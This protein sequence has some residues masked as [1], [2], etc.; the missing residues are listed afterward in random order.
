MNFLGIQTRLTV[1][2]FYR[3]RVDGIFGQLS[4][5]A[6]LEAVA[7]RA[8]GDR[9]M[10]LGRAM[11]EQLPGHAIDTELRLA[12]FLAQAAHETAGFTRFLELGSGDGPDADPYDDYLQRYDGRADLGNREPGDGERYRGRGIFQLT[13]RAN[14]RRYGAKLGLPLEQ[15][16]ELAALPINAVRIAASYWT[17]RQINLAADRDDLKA[18]TKAING[19]LNG[20]ASRAAFLDQA[21]KYLGLSRTGA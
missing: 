14:Y 7:G 1:G 13:G 11:A 5:Q 16:P 8:L 17:E 21:R 18:V 3:A 15:R 10:A 19:G 20:L 6:L 2:G 4:W 9:G 12:H